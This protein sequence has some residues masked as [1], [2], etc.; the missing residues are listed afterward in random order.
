MDGNVT[1]TKRLQRTSVT[2]SNFPKCQSSLVRRLV[3]AK[4]DPAKRRIREWLSKIDD[5]HLLGFGLT[6]QDIA[7]CRNDRSKTDGYARR[8][9]ASTR[10]TKSKSPALIRS[11]PRL[12]I[13]SSGL[14]RSKGAGFRH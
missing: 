5:E 11:S 8:A 14:R 2:H 3:Q 4:D 9:D 10:R 1:M 13:T 7:I 12:D 6:P